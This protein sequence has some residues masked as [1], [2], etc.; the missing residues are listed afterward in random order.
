MSDKSDL[1]LTGTVHAVPPPRTY[2]DKTYPNLVLEIDPGK[3]PQYPKFECR[4]T[5]AGVVANLGVGSTVKAY[6][7]VRGREYTNKKT[8]EVDWFT[9]VQVYKLDVIERVEKYA[10][11]PSFSGSAASGDPDSDIPF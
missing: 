3:Y 9:S 5:L 4:D 1:F 10:P 8:G 11:P 6:F 7:N 2:N